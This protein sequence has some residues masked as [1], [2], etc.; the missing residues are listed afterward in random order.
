MGDAGDVVA[1]VG[2]SFVLGFVFD[3]VATL[4]GFIPFAGILHVVGMQV[5]ATAL[6]H[7]L[8]IAVTLAVVINYMVWSLV[9]FL[10]V[11]LFR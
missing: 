3:A 6:F 5:S 11:F 8:N 4:F 9:G 1:I 7:I 10:I 2:L